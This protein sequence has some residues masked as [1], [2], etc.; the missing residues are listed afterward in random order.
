MKHKTNQSNRF[1]YSGDFKRVSF[2]KVRNPVDQV[3]KHMQGTLG[4]YG[5]IP[6][7]YVRI[8][9]NSHEI[10]SWVSRMMLMFYFPIEYCYWL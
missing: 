4:I 3:L 8:N 2:D 10:F 9:N 6:N 7:L 5:G 1:E